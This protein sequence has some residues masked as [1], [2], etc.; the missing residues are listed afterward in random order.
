MEAITKENIIEVLSSYP[1]STPKKMW[2]VLKGEKDFSTNGK[3]EIR[4]NRLLA[5]L[6]SMFMDW[7]L[8]QVFHIEPSLRRYSV[9]KVEG[10][11]LNTHFRTSLD[12]TLLTITPKTP[13]Y[14]VNT[15]SRPQEVIISYGSSQRVVT[16][17]H[18]SAVVEIQP[19]FYGQGIQFPVPLE[20]LVEKG[21]S[22]RRCPDA[23][24]VLLDFR[25]EYEEDKKDAMVKVLTLLLTPK[26]VDLRIHVVES[27]GVDVQDRHRKKS[28][29]AY[30]ENLIN[31]FKKPGIMLAMEQNLIGDKLLGDIDL[32]LV[33]PNAL[34][35]FHNLLRPKASNG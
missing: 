5:K 10:A 16:K 28:V 1:L 6:Q 35:Y 24:F 4:W 15:S 12:G 2:E 14:V 22:I 34:R 9:T 29:P 31:L 21:I 27:D 19:G 17:E 20:F 11:H 25:K 8:E 30:Y 33:D 18:G 32:L 23:Y 13:L 7:E 26:L 3:A